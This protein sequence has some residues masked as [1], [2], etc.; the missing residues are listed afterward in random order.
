MGN[1]IHNF[2]KCICHSDA[3]SRICVCNGCQQMRKVSIPHRSSP[4][5]HN[6]SLPFLKQVIHSR[7]CL[8]CVSRPIHLIVI[9]MESFRMVDHICSSFV[10]CLGNFFATNKSP[11]VRISLPWVKNF[12]RYALF[13]SQLAGITYNTHEQSIMND[14]AYG[15][16]LFHHLDF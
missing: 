10:I 9:W 11:F 3:K 6:S 7:I 1:H 12:S 4:A 2:Y 16:N 13:D 14:K 5:I 8:A 15:G